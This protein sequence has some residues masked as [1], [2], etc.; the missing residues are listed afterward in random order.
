MIK[1]DQTRLNLWVAELLALIH[2]KIWSWAQKLNSTWTFLCGEESCLSAG[3]NRSFRAW[4]EFTSN[5]TLAKCTYIAFKYCHSTNKGTLHREMSLTSLGKCSPAV[6]KYIF[7]KQK[8][9]PPEQ[10]EHLG[11]IPDLI[12]INSKFLQTDR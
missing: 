5:L 1:T 6:Y 3:G 11:I 7:Q 10:S 8:Q 4:I 12:L 2:Q 9:L